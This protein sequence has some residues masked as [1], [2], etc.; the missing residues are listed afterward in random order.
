MF[1]VPH[2]L[3]VGRLFKNIKPKIFLGTIKIFLQTL[4]A[5]PFQGSPRREIF[6]YIQYLVWLAFWCPQWV[7]GMAWDPL[8]MF[9]CASFHSGS[10]RPSPCPSG[11]PTREFKLIKTTSTSSPVGLPAM[12]MMAMMIMMIMMIIKG[13]SWSTASVELFCQW[14]SS[15]TFQRNI[16]R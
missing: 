7:G 8:T 14:L 13:C 2:A 3:V 4:S 16:F 1:M 15:G 12:V 9:P 5:K 11:S 10:S 6:V